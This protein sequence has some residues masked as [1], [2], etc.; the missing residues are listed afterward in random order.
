[1]GLRLLYVEL[2]GFN[3]GANNFNN[4]YVFN[5]EEHDLLK[6]LT[7]AGNKGVLY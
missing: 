5:R 7:K 1:M 2:H 3:P 4:S 6:P